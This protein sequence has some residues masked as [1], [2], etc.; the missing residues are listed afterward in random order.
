MGHSRRERIAESLLEEISSLLRDEVRDP[1]VGF[2]TLT[3]VRVTPDLSQARVFVT[4]MGNDAQRLQSLAALNR[5]AGFLQ[6]QIFRR[7]RLKKALALQFEF[8]TSVQSGNRIEELLQ[9]IHPSTSD[10]EE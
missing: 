5:A 8:D 7:L 4:V 10:E 6:R 2:V 9:Q 1:R 3:E